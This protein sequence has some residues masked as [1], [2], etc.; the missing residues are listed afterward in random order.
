LC[1]LSKPLNT[2]YKDPVGQFTSIAYLLGNTI[3]A[4]G[5]KLYLFEI[6]LF[7][8]KKAFGKV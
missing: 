6:Y 3:H 1:Q 8:Y 5:F 4:R 7:N 2:L